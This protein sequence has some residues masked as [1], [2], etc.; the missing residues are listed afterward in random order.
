MHGFYRASSGNSTKCVRRVA[1]RHSLLG[2][3]GQLVELR[4][5]R[6]LLDPEVLQPLPDVSVEIFGGPT[7]RRAITDRDGR[8]AVW[9]LPR[10]VHRVRVDL[11]PPLRL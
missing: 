7:T 4:P 6:R 9:D 8:F 1:A 2:I 5:K 3:L 11:K 10:G